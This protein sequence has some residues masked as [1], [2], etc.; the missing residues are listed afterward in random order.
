MFYYNPMDHEKKSWVSLDV[1]RAELELLSAQAPSTEIGWATDSYCINR[2]PLENHHGS[3]WHFRLAPRFNKYWQTARKQTRDAEKETVLLSR[4]KGNSSTT[5]TRTEVWALGWVEGY[6]LLQIRST[7]G[8]FPRKTVVNVQQWEDMVST[9]MAGRALWNS[10]WSFL[11][12]E[13]ETSCLFFAFPKKLPFN[14]HSEKAWGIRVKNT[15]K[16][17]RQN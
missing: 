12:T 4:M 5:A 8:T 16:V 9:G 1:T 15:P 11:S 17:H 2:V 6:K 3:G 10:G 7:A 13:L 14:C